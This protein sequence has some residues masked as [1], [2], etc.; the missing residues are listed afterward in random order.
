[1]EKLLFKKV[2]PKATLPTRGSGD[3]CG[4]DVYSLEDTVIEP[5]ARKAV[6]TG[7]AV[8]VPGGFYGRMAPRSGLALKFGIDVMAGVID[9]DYRGEVLCLLINL[10]ED[11]FQIRAGDRIAQLIIEKVAIREPIWSEELPV[12]ER[13]VMGFGSTGT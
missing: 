2:H 12:T 13:G 7:F 5:A 3:A 11:A 10:G 8:A 1:M 6:R 4:L 9:A